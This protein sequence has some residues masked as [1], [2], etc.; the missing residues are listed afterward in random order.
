MR[1][2]LVICASFAALGLMACPPPSTEC[3]T[4]N[5]AGCG[6]LT[7]VT[8]ISLYYPWIAETARKLGSALAP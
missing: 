2:S 3:V 6:G 8:P 1:P 4:G 7:G 5:E